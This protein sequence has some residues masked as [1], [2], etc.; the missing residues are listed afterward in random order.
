[1]REFDLIRRY[2]APLATSPGAAGLGDDVAVLEAGE[3]ARIVT[4]DTIVEGVHFLSADPPE[5]VGRKLVRV[6]VSDILAKGARPH[7]ALLSLVWPAGRAE[8]DL[9]AFARGL[10]E[11][12]AAFGVSLIGGDTTGG[13][14]AIVATLTLTGRCLGAGPVRRSGGRSGDG[15]FVTG[16]IGAGG[17]GLRAARGE[18]EDDDLAGAYRVPRLPA[19]EVAGLVARH[20]SAAM[21]VSDGLLGDAAKLAAASGTGAAIAL[22]S[23]P[24]VRAADTTGERLDMA[25]AGDDY[26]VILACR[27]E[28]VGALIEEAG[29]AGVG[30]TRIGELGSGP[31]LHLS[32]RGQPVTLPEKLAFEHQG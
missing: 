26:Q 10:G 3:G 22:E 14:D 8:S 18:I 7:E 27:P 28:G 31:G 23:V 32:D 16:A 1:M 9:E 29:A 17:R 25:T 20:A 19:M 6:N 5:T 21:D 24:F 11:D 2:F 15:L 12:L 4:T 13:T 30:L